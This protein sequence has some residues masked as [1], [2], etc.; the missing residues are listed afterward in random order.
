MLHDA[1]KAYLDAVEQAI[2]HEVM[3]GPSEIE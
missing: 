2:L 3:K 1:L